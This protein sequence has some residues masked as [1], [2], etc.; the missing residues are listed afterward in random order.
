[1]PDTTIIALVGIISAAF[2]GAITAIVTGLFSW[3]NLRKQLDSQ[4][5]SLREELHQRNEEA[6]RA[7]LSDTRKIYLIPLREHLLG[8]LAS[9]LGYH[10]AAEQLVTANFGSLPEGQGEQLTENYRHW[11]QMIADASAD[12]AIYTTQISDPLLLELVEG[13]WSNE[14][15]AASQFDPFVASAGA[16][17]SDEIEYGRFKSL[18]DGTRND[19][20]ILLLKM[21]KRIEALLAGE[22]TSE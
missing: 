7:R 5:G 15:Q 18:L 1:M 16:F 12:Y 21:N 11:Q 10:R 14:V 17:F 4:I 20:S 6:R 19:R 8:I 13:L 2:A 22:E 3:L 9:I